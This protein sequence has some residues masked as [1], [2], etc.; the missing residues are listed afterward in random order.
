MLK[1]KVTMSLLIGTVVP[2]P[3]PK[4]LMDALASAQVQ[5]SAGEASGFQLSF[6]FSD[7]SYLD[8]AIVL[9][10]GV[11]PIVGASPVAPPATRQ[12]KPERTTP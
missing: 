11:G 12:P 7:K 2:K 10:A 4:H 6:S 9:L 8:E 5:T 1:G 3:A